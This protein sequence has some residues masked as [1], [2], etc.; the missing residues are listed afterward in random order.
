MRHA[1]GTCLAPTF[2]GF[3]LS[4]FPGQSSPGSVR[5][6]VEITPIAPRQSSRRMYRLP[7]FEIAPDRS[8]PP[9]EFGFGV[10]PSQADRV[11][12]GSRH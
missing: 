1:V 8:L 5:L 9:L 2:G 6:R 10:R 4:I 11:A 12:S 3:F 7:I